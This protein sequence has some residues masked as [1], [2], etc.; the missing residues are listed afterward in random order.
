MQRVALQVLNEDAALAA[1]CLAEAG[2]FHPE[3]AQAWAQQLPEFPGESYRE[4]YRG[5]RARLDK[6]LA[7]CSPRGREPPP[8]PR[9]VSERELAELDRWLHDVWILCSRCQEGLRRIEEQKKH[10]EQLLKTLDNF[11]ALDIDLGLLAGSKR[12]LDVHIG[13][14]PAE[15]VSRL[16]Q[17]VG[18]AGYTL[19]PF[20][21]HDGVE[22]VVVAGLQGREAKIRYVLQAAGWRSVTIPPELHDRP[23]KVREELERRAEQVV[24]ETD[25]QCQLIETTQKEF[26]DKLVA[27]ARTLALVEPYVE[28][29]EALRGR[30]GLALISGWAPRKDL[31]R[32]RARLQERFGGRFVLSARDPLPQERA[33]VP[34]LIRH[35]RWLAPFAELV[36]NYGVPRYGEF[37]PTWLFA[38]TFVA[39]FGMMFGDVGHGAVIVAAAAWWRRRLGRF[40]PFIVA[41]GLSSTVFGALYGSL[42]GFEHVIPAVWMSPLTDPV[43]MLTLAF[44]WGAGFILVATGLTVYNRVTEGRYAEALFGGKGVAG[45]LLYLGLLYGGWRWIDAGAFG[46]AETAG[47]AI[48]LALILGYHWHHYRAP[49]A[50]RILVVFIEGFETL[51]SYF[52]NTLSFL[53][54]AAFSLNHVALAIAIFTLAGMMQTA[55]QWITIVLGN[56]FTLVL[57][58]AIVA[59]QALRLEYYEGFSRFFGGDGR[60]FKPLKLAVLGSEYKV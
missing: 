48:P 22:H 39:M 42:F 35:P 46:A 31:P 20:L 43:R 52:S 4:L 14:V 8:E 15:N 13:M 37:D 7:Y 3:T 47:I 12:F 18:L 36:R 9:A 27:A 19:T 17:A 53:R 55:G 58:G 29:G 38:L 56:V 21:R 16:R 5:A 44:Y 24:E 1:Q 59:I 11:A 34:S 10:V 50:E 49:L 57:E 40:T 41:V 23:E 2:V 54:V 51:I 45:I 30:G 28:L 25:A 32:L 6:I 33:R 60:E 26:L